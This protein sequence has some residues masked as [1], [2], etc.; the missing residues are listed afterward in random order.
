MAHTQARLNANNIGAKYLSLPD[1]NIDVLTSDALMT[2]YKSLTP[3]AEK[4][5]D[6]LNHGKS[7]KGYKYGIS[8]SKGCLNLFLLTRFIY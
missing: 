7:K 8:K 1:Y 3:T 5:G 6:L 4:L 2:D